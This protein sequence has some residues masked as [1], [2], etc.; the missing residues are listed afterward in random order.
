VSYATLG[1]IGHV[2][3]GKTTLVKTLTGTNTDRLKEE[4]KR[5]ISIALGYAY[6]DVPEGRWG[7]VDV[8]G[9]E[10]FIRTMVS[11]A[12]GIRAVLLVLDVNEGVKPQTTE[13]IHIAELLGIEYGIIA[14]T[15]CDTADEEM[16][17]LA[18]LELRDHLEGTF[19]EDAP[20][21][22]TAALTGGGIPEIK[23]ALDDLL[24]KIPPL[25]RED[26]VYLPID[27]VF[28]MTGFGTV[29]TGTLQ[30]GV[31]RKDAPVE[32]YPKELEGQIRELQSHGETVSEV[33]PGH[34]TAVN[35][36]GMDKAS[37]RRGDVLATPGSLQTGTF[38]DV[39][40]S[41]LGD[42]SEPVKQRSVVRLLYG[43]LETFGRVHLLDRDEIE[44]GESVPCQIQLDEPG[45]VLFRD[46]LILR[47]YSPMVTIGGGTILGV[48]DKRRKRREE[49]ETEWLR[50]LVKGDP[51]EILRGLLR[52]QK[53]VDV[54]EFSIRYRQTESEVRAFADLHTIELI[55][56]NWFVDEVST[57]ELSESIFPIVE[58]YFRDQ[59][60]TNGL[61][62]EMLKER[63]RLT[64]PQPIIEYVLE[65]LVS[66]K[67]IETSDGTY[68]PVGKGGGG[69]LKGRE[70]ELADEIEAAFRD[71]G[72]QP[73]GIVEVCRNDKE[74]IKLYRYLVDHKKLVTISLANKAKTLSNTLVFHTD[75]LE[76][77]EQLIRESFSS[78]KPFSPSEARQILGASR[79]YVMPLLECMDAIGVTKRTSEGRV[80]L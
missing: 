43:T 19:L 27:R 20:I 36:R 60:T 7:V 77:A 57:Q 14:L 40:L 61:T 55:V 45:A 52:R 3:H 58:E 4:Q 75:S 17:E 35:L 24:G 18:Q 9:H 70:L 26:S 54:S 21:I 37:L 5:G 41:I 63:A 78:G 68:V 56:D 69:G 15:K 76:N 72:L 39:H 30:R 62:V 22:E 47:A 66:L 49:S 16:R 79:K 50:T 11:G 31:L 59:P 38:L 25:S 71:G 1:V 67:K 12:T 29:I 51:V 65:H 44:P 42:V 34:R 48:S 8:P 74:R 32:V 13:H 2:D 80:L 28:S 33:E 10:K 23:T 46:R 53:V 6:L 64:Y 73:P